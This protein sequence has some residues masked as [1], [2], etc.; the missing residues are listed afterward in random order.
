MRKTICFMIVSFFLFCKPCMA[1]YHHEGEAD[2]PNFLAAYPALEGSKL[3]SCALCHCGGEYEKSP[4]DYIEV[5]SCQWCHITYGYDKS[6]DIEETIN[7]YGMDYKNAGR[8]TIAFTAIEGNDSDG[9]GYTNKQEIDALSFP[10]DATDDPTK[11]YAPSVTY[12]LTELESLNSHTQFMLM[13]T[14]R[15]GDWYGEYQG[16]PFL[17]LLRD[18]GMI[19]KTTTAVTAYSPDGYF[20]TYELK[21]GGDF[22]YI[23]GTYPQAQFYY[24]PQADKAN[25]GWCDYSSPSR[26]GRENGDLITVQGGL[27]FILAYKRD[28]TYLE[29]GYLDEENRLPV[30]CEGPF[31]AVPPQMFPSPPDQSS[32]SEIQDVIWPYNETADHNAGYSA[33][34][35]AAI[36]VEPL[37]EGTTDINWYESGWDYIENKE[38]IIYGNLA[39]GNIEG[40]VTDQETS[41]PIAQATVSTD[42]GGYSTVTNET[43]SFLLTGLK[44]D[45]YS[46]RASAR[47]YQ[48]ASQ[49]V[50]VTKDT[51]ETVDFSLTPG[52]SQCPIESMIADDQKTLALL[53][54]YRDNVL[55]KNHLGRKY[56]SAYYENAVEM[57]VL[58]ISDSVIREKMFEALN[59]IIPSIEQVM[60]GKKSALSNAQTIKINDL[61]KAV[62]TAGSLKLQKAIGQF[63]TDFANGVFIK[64]FLTP[65]I[66]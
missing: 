52:S 58:I 1:A 31:R 13:N 9:D 22:Y 24:D 4:G 6:G 14:T 5:S 29:P 21:P 50:T 45:T 15:S 49:S 32:T 23:D 61:I 19:E 11:I 51:T 55:I 56:V 33:R 43:G 46:L 12:T 48:T 47:G 38:L 36:R 60:N 37:P 42:K 16:V 34:T 57:V 54:N 27:K 39:S 62:K 3:D 64:T 40:L 18:A 10:G 65:V 20:Y 30:F 8:S 2:T 63:E 7:P 17:D 28:G 35:V 26:T 44:T 59:A 41:E 53:R 66:K 25:G